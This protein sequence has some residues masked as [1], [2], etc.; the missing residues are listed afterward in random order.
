MENKPPTFAALA[1]RFAEPGEAVQVDRAA[2]TSA[3]ECAAAANIL[4]YVAELGSPVRSL[5]DLPDAIAA[6]EDEELSAFNCR[7]GVAVSH[8][9]QNSWVLFTR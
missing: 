2:F 6:L 9:S 5:D 1:S 3:G 8:A 4:R 7:E